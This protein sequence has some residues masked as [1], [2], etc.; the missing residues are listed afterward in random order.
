[1][2]E[3]KNANRVLLHACCGICSG[4][5]IKFLLENQY[6]PVVYF[7][8]PNIQPVNDYIKRLDAQKTLCS[9]FGVELIEEQYEPEVFEDYIK[10][11]E[12]EPERG[13]RCDK[14]FEL[15]LNRTAQKAKELNINIFTSSI[16]ISPHKLYPHLKQIGEDAAKKYA[17][18][19]LAVDFKKK[20]GFL[21]T[22][23]I[24]NELGLYRQN[25]CGCK[26]SFRQVNTQQ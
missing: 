4:Y 6:L 12:T 11:L 2:Q 22:N 1:M 7:Y 23:K 14:C 10:G 25:Y 16:A 18:Q 3:Q 26:Y 8:N 20:D 19:F 17:I 9:Y 15:R 21:K 13:K 24:A 5:P